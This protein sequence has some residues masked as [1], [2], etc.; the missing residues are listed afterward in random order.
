MADV[1]TYNEVPC[2]LDPEAFEQTADSAPSNRKWRIGA[3]L[4][5]VGFL[6][7]IAACANQANAPLPNAPNQHILGTGHA[8]FSTVTH[9]RD[10]IRLHSQYDHTLADELA[11]GATDVGLFPTNPHDVLDECSE[12]TPESHLPFSQDEIYS[13]LTGFHMIDTDGNGCIDSEEMFHMMKTSAPPGVQEPSQYQAEQAVYDVDVCYPPHC[14]GQLEWLNANAQAQSQPPQHPPGPPNCDTMFNIMD[15]NGD[16]YISR[17][18]L[19]NFMTDPSISQQDL[20]STFDYADTNGN[21]YLNPNEF[22]K[23]FCPDAAPADPCA[24]HCGSA[25]VNIADVMKQ[26]CA[27]CDECYR[28][29]R[30]DDADD[31]D[32]YHRKD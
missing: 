7:V 28:R 29:H 8:V 16:G 31:D 11:N 27:D 19:S 1:S 24:H 10:A 4:G 5:A 15:M 2:S 22:E 9:V 21:E 17:S 12:L 3:S 13:Q 14:I 32:H 26:E 30:P 6:L 25:C 18:E 20:R 23:V